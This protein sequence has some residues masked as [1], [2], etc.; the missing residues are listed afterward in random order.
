MS[1]SYACSRHS[2]SMS[3]TR[4]TV[5]PEMGDGG[6]EKRVIASPPLHLRRSSIHHALQ[7]SHHVESAPIKLLVRLV[8][9]SLNQ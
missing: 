9:R 3:P 2:S 1:A 8:D 5:G 6:P 7:E 4:R